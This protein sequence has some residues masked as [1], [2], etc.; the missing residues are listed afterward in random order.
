MARLIDA[1]ALLEKLKKTDRYFSVKFDIAEAP[2][3]DA[4]PR[5]EYER[6]KR[7]RDAAVADLKERADCEY[8]K[9]WDSQKHDC[10]DYAHDYCNEEHG[11]NWEW[12]GVQ[13]E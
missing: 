6:L 4:V 8:C 3:I 12:R 1:D 5:S 7:E 11:L 9:F 13:D 10:V 2:T